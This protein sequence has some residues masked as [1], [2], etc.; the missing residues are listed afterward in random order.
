MPYEA[1]KQQ[2][3]REASTEQ[4]QAFQQAQAGKDH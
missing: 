1:W 2:Y 3:Q 4:Q